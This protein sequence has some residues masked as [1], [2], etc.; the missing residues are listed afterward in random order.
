MSESTRFFYGDTLR[1]MLVARRSF[2]TL[3]SNAARVLSTKAGPKSGTW[4]DKDL[5][6]DTC[7]SHRLNYPH[8]RDP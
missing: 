3:R 7:A 4:I 1:T 5:G 6:Y 2:P 8:A